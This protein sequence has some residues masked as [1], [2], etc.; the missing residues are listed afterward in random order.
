MQTKPHRKHPV[1]SLLLRRQPVR[2][3]DEAAAAEDETGIVRDA[4]EAAATKGGRRPDQYS[5]ETPVT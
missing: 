1:R 5:E 2:A 4:A 3:E